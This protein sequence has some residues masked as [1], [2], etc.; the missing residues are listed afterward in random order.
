MVAAGALLGAAD[1]PAKKKIT[2]K[3]AMKD[4][5]GGLHT[6]VIEGKATAA[7]K[8]KLL[9]YA[10][11]LPGLKPPKGSKESWKKLTTALLKATTAAVEGKDGG[12]AALGKAIN[13]KACHTPHKIYPP[14]K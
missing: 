14:K 3:T 12:T 8:T 5:K 7:E 9:A 4:I 10:K 1:K 13:C 6:K 2:I 11:A